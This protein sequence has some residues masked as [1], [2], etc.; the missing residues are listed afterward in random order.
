MATCCWR[1]WRP[2]AAINR[3][4]ANY[5]QDE[6]AQREAY[7]MTLKML[8]PEHIETT[9]QRAVWAISLTETGK[10]QQSYQESQAALAT[11]RLL[12]PVPGSF[13][14]WTT[15]AAAAFS[16]CLTE[17]FQECESLAREAIQT[18]GP[19]PEPADL[20]LYEARSYLALALAGEGR[21]AEALPLLKE[22]VEFYRARNR[23]G[24]L[25]SALEAAYAK[26]AGTAGR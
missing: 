13:Q 9:H 23:Q 16:S 15:T 12:F 14:L 21:N 26:A 4:L 3:F 11:T 7:Q 10:I 6:A 2:G 17:H 8:G 24:P 20:R 1:V 22:T 25:R 19:H 5:E 18:L